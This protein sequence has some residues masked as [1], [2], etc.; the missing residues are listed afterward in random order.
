MTTQ[1]VVRSVDGTELSRTVVPVS[2]EW[3]DCFDSSGYI[4]RCD[5]G[6]VVRT[7][8]N[9]HTCFVNICAHFSIENRPVYGIMWRNMV[10][11]DRP[12]MAI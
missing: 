7:V 9:A 5:E 8:H 12:Q 3:I 11:P 2:C 4:G 10:Q 1:S 6:Y